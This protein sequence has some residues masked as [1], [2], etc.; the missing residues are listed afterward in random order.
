M[1]GVPFADV[2]RDVGAGGWAVA[3]TL[4]TPDGQTRIGTGL[5]PGDNSKARTRAVR[6][7]GEPASSAGVLGQYLRVVWLTPAMGQA[8]R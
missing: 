2:A 4:E 7:D 6:I 5:E 3:A 1:R 8:L